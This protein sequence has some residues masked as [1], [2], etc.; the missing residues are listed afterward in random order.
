MTGEHLQ[1]VH[2]DITRME[3]DAIVNAANSGLM[4]GGG[5]DGAIHGAGGPA[6]GNACRAIRDA[7]GGCPTGQAVITTGG[8]LPAPYVIHAV[9]PVWQGGGKGEAELLAACYRN[10]LALAESHNLSS[11]AFPAISCGIYGYPAE[12]AAAIAVAELQKPRPG[13]SSLRRA[14]LVAFSADMAE[15]YR[16]LL[17]ARAVS[18]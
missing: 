15:L 5:V 16:R 1:V 11:I 4:G 18:Q 12:Q 9:G 6:I 2:G 13:E 8:L 3:V 17:E 14:L 7:Q 10:S